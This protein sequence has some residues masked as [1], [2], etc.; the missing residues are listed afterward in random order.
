MPEFFILVDGA[1]IPDFF[2][3]LGRK[4]PQGVDVAESRVNTVANAAQML[5][6]FVRNRHFAFMPPVEHLVEVLRLMTA[7]RNPFP[8]MPGRLID[9]IE[10]QRASR[11][12]K[13][14]EPQTAVTVE[15]R[16]PQTSDWEVNISRLFSWETQVQALAIFEQAP[17]TGLDKIA[18][19]RSGDQAVFETWRNW[20]A[21]GL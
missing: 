13:A 14:I 17:G 12:K 9:A 4:V 6:E 5:E 20:V 21:G 7:T 10:R 2:S 8:R 3:V 19:L 16:R 18:A 15:S 11:E 1:I